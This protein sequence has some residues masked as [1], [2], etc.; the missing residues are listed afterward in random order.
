MKDKISNKGLRVFGTKIT[1]A[2]SGFFLL[3]IFL[4]WGITYSSG[5]FKHSF[6]AGIVAVLLISCFAF[7]SL[8]SHEM[9]HMFVARKIGIRVPE[10]IVM[11]F[12][13]LAILEKDLTS[14]KQEFFISIAGP[15]MSLLLFGFFTLLNF[16]PAGDLNI[17]FSLLGTLNLYWAIFNLIPVFPMDGGRVF[18]SLVWLVKGSKS[19]AVRVCYWTNIALAVIV[20]LGD[21]LLF[22]SVFDALW[23]LMILAIMVG[24]AG[25]EYKIV[26]HENPKMAQTVESV[27]FIPF[28]IVGILMIACVNLYN[29]IKAKIRG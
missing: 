10:I 3:G 25:R 29:G 15:V 4:F 1:F 7:A 13:M 16:F 28:L 26:C 8:L 5:I 14:A 24:S 6:F 11:G 22:K 27:I 20:P 12:G 18:R 19:K 23:I 2:A 21:F 9:A 17:A